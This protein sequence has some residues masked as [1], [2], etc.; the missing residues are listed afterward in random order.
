MKFF[1]ASLAVLSLGCCL[2]IS[3]SAQMIG[4]N[5][6]IPGHYLEIGQANPGYFAA[7]PPPAGYHPYPAG[8]TLAEVYDYGHDGWTVGTPPLMGDYTYPGSPFEGFAIQVGSAAQLN[9]SFASNGAITGTGSLVGNNVS[10]TNVGG[11][12]IGNWSGSCMGGQLQLR[13][14]TRVDTNASWVNVTTKMYNTGATALN[15]I[16]YIRTC[17]PDNDEA[18]SYSFTTNNQVVYQNDV[19]HRVMVKALGTVYTYAYMGLC[20]KDQR[21]RAFVYD[22]WP[23]DFYVTDL[24]TI[25]SGAAGYQYTPGVWDDGDIA[26]GLE[27]YI[28][29]I[30]AHDST[31]VSYAYTFLNSDHGVDSAFP[32]PGIIVNGGTPVY[33]PAIGAPIYDTF[34]SC[35]H[36]GVTMLPVNLSYSASTGVWT[37]A[38]W[39]WAPGT[40]LS[41]TTGTNVTINLGA[42]SGV[43]TFTITGTDSLPGTSCPPGNHRVIY[44]TIVPCFGGSANSPCLGNT[45]T[46]TALGDSIGATYQWLNP[47]GTV[48]GTTH[49]LNITPSVW[50]DTGTWKI[51]RFLGGVYDTA[52]V[53]VTLHTMPALTVTYN[54]DSICNASGGT[55]LTDTMKIH[56]SPALTGDVFAWTGPAGF[57]STLANPFIAPFIASESGVYHV[58]V[59]DIYG[60]VGTA[61][62]NIIPCFGASSNAPCIG[63]PLY[64]FVTGDSLGAT[65]QWISPSGTVAGSLPNLTISPSVW[66][67]TG[68][69][70]VIRNLGGV[71]DTMITHVVIHPLPSYLM[72]C[73]GDS[74]CS[75]TSSTFTD[76]MKLYCYPYVAGYTY[77][78]SGPGGFTSTLENP[79]VTPYLP[80]DTGRY[81]VTVTDMYGCSDTSSVL[82]RIIPPIIAPTITGRNHYCTGDPFIPFGINLMPGATA[83]WYLDSVGGTGSTISPPVDNSYAHTVTVWAS[84]IEGVCEGLRSS[85]TVVVDTTPAPAVLT[86][87]A[88]ICTDSA[89]FL[90]ATDG[91]SGGTYSWT[92][93]LGFTSTLQNPS[94]LNAQVNNSGNYTVVYSLPTSCHSSATINV[95]VKPKP[96]P[97]TI[98]ANIPCDGFALNLSATSNA[99]STFNWN[100]PAGFSAAGSNPTVNPAKLGVN[101]GIYTVIATLDLCPSFPATFNAA[102]RANPAAPITHDTAFCQYSQSLPLMADSLLD[103]ESGTWNTLTWYTTG[104]GSTTVSEPFYPPTNNPGTFTWYVLQTSTYGCIS[105]RAAENIHILDTPAFHIWQSSPYACQDSSVTLHY[106]GPAYPALTYA[107]TIPAQGASIVGGAWDSSFIRVQFDSLYHDT[108]GL[109]VWDH[110]WNISCHSNQL[111]NV[112]VIK[113][114]TA[115]GYIKPIVCAGDTV[116]IELTDR[117]DNAYSFAWNFQFGGNDQMIW[118]S[119]STSGP[120]GVCWHEGGTKDVTIIPYTVE[121]CSGIRVH[122]TVLVRDLPNPIFNHGHG[123]KVCADDSVLFIADM[124]DSAN[125]KYHWSPEHFFNQN[126]HHSCWGQVEISSDVTLTITDEFNCTASWSIWYDSDPECC[127]VA[128][129]SAFSPN[130]DG[131]N[132][133]FRPVYEGYHRFHIFR[134][135]N[136]WGQTV[137]EST[138]NKMEWDGNYAGVPQDMGTYYYYLKFDCDGK[139]YEKRGD[140]TLIR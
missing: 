17:D 121:G 61:S 86:T 122:D 100:G 128:I 25:Y 71:L 59:T 123:D 63:S 74:L 120:Y 32:E 82:A 75:S 67:D 16:Y 133:Y 20:T 18:H 41:S 54:A 105:P 28:C 102:I 98:T 79:T 51:V 104:S 111:T 125:Y 124:G 97:P 11:H 106:E 22:S 84:Q 43:T 129:P 81:H 33:P 34:F 66:S 138:N 56:L 72:A 117:S 127:K 14:E 136:R 89:L 52:T 44:L 85:F 83:L 50:A 12:L 40:G 87:N 46:L 3:A 103:S 29:S 9:Y 134:V 115:H 76:T 73:N 92:G 10:Y 27:Y 31:M 126:G 8:S 60:C 80:A 39:T 62:I 45:L 69:W 15:N 19:D 7:D 101:D 96:A 130:G 53:H 21:A 30:P 118:S 65:F 4:T 95:L 24:S 38:S 94:I 77:S 135:Q 140:V 131:H 132:D 114:P 116:Q 55:P 107:W 57:T 6:F 35:A 108:V 112:H 78:W 5:I 139:T 64:V 109:Y 26:I 37:W 48:A 90:Y 58:T 1:S 47:G 91:L 68:N 36:P 49:T 93:P 88:P 23:L 70:K 119:S 110:N 99:G 2:S 137:F 42:L 113:M 13:M